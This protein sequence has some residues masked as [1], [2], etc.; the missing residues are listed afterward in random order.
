MR[1]ITKILICIFIT[2]T[3]CQLAAAKDWGGVVPL[4][5]TRADV[6][7]LLGPPQTGTS[8]VYQ[9]ANERIAVTYV[10]GPCA[11]GW[12]VPPGTVVSLTVSPQPPL[13][14]AELKL[15]ESKFEKRRDIHIETRYYY[16]NQAEGINYTVEVGVGAVIGIEYYPTAND[17]YLHCQ[18]LKGATSKP[19]EAA[20]FDEYVGV[21]DDEQRRLDKFATLV[22]QDAGTQGY[23]IAYA[24]RGARLSE[25]AA[26]GR[27]LKNYLVRQRG[28]D[29]RQV[30]TITGGQREQATVELYLVPAGVPPPA[31][32]PTLS[33]GA[34]QP[35]DKR[36]Q[37]RGRVARP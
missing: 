11:Y 13:K 4:R 22:R 36:G 14:L 1:H 23:V 3:L 18:P 17:N 19:K 33:S 27:R 32:T 37:R 34:T 20:K 6:E 7:R 29:R 35:M 2:F 28:L 25:A 31:A 24:G 30:V 12:D 8:N 21:P 26:V 16:I 10:E 15:D 9:T 5:S